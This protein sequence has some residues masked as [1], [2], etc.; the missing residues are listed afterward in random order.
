MFLGAFFMDSTRTSFWSDE[1]VVA[2]REFQHQSQEKYVKYLKPK[3]KKN[4]NLWFQSETG[5][6]GPLAQVLVLLKTLYTGSN[7]QL[8]VVIVDLQ[9][10]IHLFVGGGG[11]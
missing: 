5:H 11:W 10:C 3:G 4:L 8:S 9:L 2:V 7:G 6:E 1:G